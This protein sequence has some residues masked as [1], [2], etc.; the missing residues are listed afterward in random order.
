MHPSWTTLKSLFYQEPLSTL[1]EEILPTTTYVPKKDRICTI[2][3]KPIDTWKV[4][5]V[6]T[7]PA[8]NHT[9]SNR[10]FLD[11]PFA[12][13]IIQEEIKRQRQDLDYKI[14]P[15]NWE[16]QGVLLLN[17]SLSV[18]IGEPKSHTQYW[19]YFISKIMQHLSTI[20]PCI[21][22]FWGEQS[23]KFIPYININP[24]NVINYTE[25]TIKEVPS[26]NDWNYIIKGVY[27]SRMEEGF[28]GNNHFLYINQILTNLKKKPIIW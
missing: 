16:K 7:E 24:F 14:T 22:V 11:K 26:V 20:N 4:V 23:Q 25:E 28:I 12:L 6:G 13:E 3:E 10:A 5:L 18:K 2:F 19:E 27:P 15:L 9:G 1:Y 17:T 8:A 21:W